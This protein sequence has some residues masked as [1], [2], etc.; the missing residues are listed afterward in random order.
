M[1]AYQ[2]IAPISTPQ[3]REMA[4]NAIEQISDEIEGAESAKLVAAIR[5][6][7]QP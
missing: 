7:N 3:Y 2:A 6:V 4:I 5:F 1:N